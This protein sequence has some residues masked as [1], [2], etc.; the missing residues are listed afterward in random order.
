MP[1]N[2][3]LIGAKFRALAADFAA[4]S[5]PTA[6]AHHLAVSADR[7]AERAGKLLLQL[8]GSFDDQIVPG[9]EGAKWLHSR[10]AAYDKPQI[11]GYVGMK[12]L[13]TQTFVELVRYFTLGERRPFNEGDFDLLTGFTAGSEIV[14]WPDWWNEKSD[15]EKL[16]YDELL[17]MQRLGTLPGCIPCEGDDVRRLKPK[18]VPNPWA[19]GDSAE[20]DASLQREKLSLYARSCNLV[21]ELIVQ[22]RGSSPLRSETKQAMTII[23]NDPGILGK[24][25]GPQLGVEPW[26]FKKNIRPLLIAEGYKPPTKGSRRG[27]WPPEKKS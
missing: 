21:A 24:V 11:S 5:L 3:E 9:P 2:E 12:D 18:P 10:R 19:G 16:E 13:A 17:E 1:T 25:L 15:A 8:D 4:A 14:P 23:D 26:D 20:P 6:N 27:W 7:V 22:E